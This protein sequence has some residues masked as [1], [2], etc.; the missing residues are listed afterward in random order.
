MLTAMFSAN[1]H[2]FKGLHKMGKGLYD[3]F[4]CVCGGGE[5]Q[6]N[7]HLLRPIWQMAL[8]DDNRPIHFNSHTY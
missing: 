4:M 2:L 6:T 3:T 5:S 8:K 1:E 7:P